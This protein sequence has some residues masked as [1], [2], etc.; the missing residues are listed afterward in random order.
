MG[1]QWD[2]NEFK[3]AAQFP[4]GAMS[5]GR[6]AFGAMDFNGISMSSSLRRNS[7]REQC[8]AGAM[9]LHSVGTQCLRRNGFQ[10]DF[11]EFKLAAQFPSGAMS[12]GRNAFG[13]MDFNGISMSSSLRRNSLREQCPADAMPSAQWISMGFQ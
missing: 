6:N 12:C 3:L 9:C 10:W 13:A 8:P 1:V 2:F 4:S 11:N 7:L 5:C